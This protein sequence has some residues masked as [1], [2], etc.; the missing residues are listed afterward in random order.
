MVAWGIYLSFGYACHDCSLSGRRCNGT[1]EFM[2]SPDIPQEAPT[3]FLLSLEQ[4]TLQRR[5]SLPRPEITQGTADGRTTCALDDVGATTRPARHARRDSTRVATQ[6]PF[7]S[8]L[9]VI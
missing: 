7:L 6:V 9:S 8:P 5:L 4:R 3:F 1:R 2:P